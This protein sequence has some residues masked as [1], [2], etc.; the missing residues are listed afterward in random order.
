MEEIFLEMAQ[1]GLLRAA[2][3]LE[4]KGTAKAKK[5]AKALRAAHAGID[6]YLNAET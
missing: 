1:M 6:D 2:R 4:K 5:L 3:A